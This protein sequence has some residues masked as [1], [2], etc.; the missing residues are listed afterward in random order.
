MSKV[1]P[2]FAVAW[3]AATLQMPQAAAT[4][5]LEF[6]AA[7]AGAGVTPS[8]QGWTRFGTPMVNNGVYLLQDNTGVPGEQSGE[9][10]SPTLPAGT[11]SRG[12][13]PYGIEFRVRPLTDVN[14]VGAAWPE[15]YLTWSDDQFNY[16]ITV[17]KFG[18]AATS[19]TGD[20]VY[21][22][23]SFSPAITGIDWS[24]P[25][26]IFIGH[27]GSGGTSVFDFYLD[28]VLQSTITDGSIARTGS[29]ARDAVDFGDGTT[30]NQDVAGEW[31]FVRVWDVNNPAAAAVPEASSLGFAAVAA[32]AGGLFARRR[33][34]QVRS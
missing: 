22:R 20:I 28:G 8:D 9:Y 10:L 27:R 2:I 25:H 23:N 32:T 26:T 24:S 3:C 30:G 34:R 4:L 1:L 6:N 31:Y 18:N 33:N 14:F 19:G 12:G 21:G 16:N 29:F 7:T 15:M 5:L 17:D 13:A 11:F